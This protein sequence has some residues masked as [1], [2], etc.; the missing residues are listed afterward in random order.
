M[1]RTPHRREGDLRRSGVYPVRCTPHSG[2]G[3]VL[4]VMGD[5]DMTELATQIAS[6]YAAG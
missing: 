5:A 2:L 6:T 4:A 1:F 3:M